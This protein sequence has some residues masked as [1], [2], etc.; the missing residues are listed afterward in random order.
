MLT[1]RSSS[2]GWKYLHFFPPQLQLHLNCALH[3]RKPP[4]LHPAL[5]PAFLSALHKS[6]HISGCRYMKSYPASLNPSCTGLPELRQT[7]GGGRSALP[8]KNSKI[9]LK[10]VFFKV[11]NCLHHIKIIFVKVDLAKDNFLKKKLW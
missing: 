2:A 4:A 1:T 9:G 5:P 3:S 11:C 6:L 8:L 10:T 7:L